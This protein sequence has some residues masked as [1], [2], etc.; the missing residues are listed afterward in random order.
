MKKIIK[1][2]FTRFKSEETKR[3]IFIRGKV[4]QLFD[5]D[6]L[7]EDDIREKSKFLSEFREILKPLDNKSVTPEYLSGVTRRSYTE[8]IKFLESFE[9]FEKLDNGEYTYKEIVDN[10]ENNFIKRTINK[11]IK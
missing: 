7:T 6:N 5:V 2:V 9:E 11:L 10:R 1:K 8:V 3:D 4:I